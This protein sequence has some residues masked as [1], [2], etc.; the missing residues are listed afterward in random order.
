MKNNF[1][2]SITIASGGFIVLLFVVVQSPV[3]GGRFSYLPVFLMPA[4]IAAAMM[5]VATFIYDVIKKTKLSV[6]FLLLLVVLLGAFWLGLKI[7]DMQID[8]TKNA[9]ETVI[10]ALDKYYADN[11]SYPEK[12]PELEPKYLDDVPKSKLGVIR[13]DFDY[14]TMS[15][16]NDYRLSFSELFNTRWTFIK[17]RES[18]M[19]DK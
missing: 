10:V 14:N 2:K 8:A 1:A 5:L 6:N 19:M 13:T 12:L 18:W 16:K 15:D 4:V 11:N 7:I 3:I 17:S 9:S